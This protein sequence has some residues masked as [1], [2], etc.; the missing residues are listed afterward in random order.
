MKYLP[1]IFV[2]AASANPPSWGD[3]VFEST[4]HVKMRLGDFRLNF[5]PQDVNH[6]ANGYS[7]TPTCHQT[8]SFS[9]CTWTMNANGPGGAAD[10][11][12]IVFEMTIYEAFASGQYSFTINAPNQFPSGL[13]SDISV[14]FYVSNANIG[15][16][17]ID[18]VPSNQK[19]Y[20][21]EGLQI[22]CPGR[23]MIWYAPFECPNSVAG[24]L[25]NIKTEHWISFH[26]A[27]GGVC[28][29]E[30]E[31]H[32]ICTDNSGNEITEVYTCEYDSD[33]YAYLWG[34]VNGPA[35]CV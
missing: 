19:S 35:V 2:A 1:L 26:T 7:N 16:C 14:D 18:N 6:Y 28:Q 24:W 23:E 34:I 30:V 15:E 17:L 4:N 25:N 13:M 27:N 8:S 32:R 5:L 11:G 20:N 12:A 31:Q 9:H 3:W 22:K 10:D 33:F 29:M 21:L